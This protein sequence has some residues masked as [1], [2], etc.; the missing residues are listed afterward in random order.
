MCV[1][2]VILYCFTNPYSL[3]R[4]VVNLTEK[5]QIIMVDNT[6]EKHSKFT[7]K[8]VDKFQIFI[9]KVLESTPKTT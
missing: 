8:D 9:A 4:S 7:K 1:V 3:V 2:N 6:S 5:I